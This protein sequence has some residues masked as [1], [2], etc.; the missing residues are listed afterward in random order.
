[1]LGPTSRLCEPASDKNTSSEIVRAGTTPDRASK[2]LDLSKS[3]RVIACFEI[4]AAICFPSRTQDCTNCPHQTVLVKI[5]A[6]LRT[7][8]KC[9][10]RRLIVRLSEQGVVRGCLFFGEPR[11]QISVQTGRP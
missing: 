1:M 2:L 8:Q 9:S 5:R 6:I 7:G 11:K 10:K 3:R 4:R